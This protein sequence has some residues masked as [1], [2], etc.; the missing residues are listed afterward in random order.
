MRTYSAVR[1]QI[2]RGLWGRSLTWLL[3]R[4][5]TIYFVAMLSLN[6]AMWFSNA[7]GSRI[8]DLNVPLQ[9]ILISRLLINLRR[10]SESDIYMGSQSRAVE[11][12]SLATG[13]SSIIFG[14]ADI[15]GNEE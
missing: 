9:L 15:F 13:I 1:L 3:F 10:A 2:R 7:V 5:G 11:D 4:D 8:S 6:F 12:L 14:R